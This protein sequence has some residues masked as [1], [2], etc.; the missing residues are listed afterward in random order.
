MNSFETPL[1]P[2]L[3]PLRLTQE[4]VTSLKDLVNIRD[5]VDINLGNINMGFPGNSVV[6]TNVFSGVASPGTQLGMLADAVLE[7]AKLHGIDA[8]TGIAPDGEKAPEIKRLQE[9]VVEVDRVK[10]ERRLA[11]ARASLSQIKQADPANFRKAVEAL[12]EEI[13]ATS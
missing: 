5:L 3:W 10:D 7:L 1:L 4:T 2:W 13:E 11:Q 8:T 6:E 9:L 12:V